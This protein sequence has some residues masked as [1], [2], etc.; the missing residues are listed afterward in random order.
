VVQE[1]VSVGRRETSPVK[2]SFGYGA[3]TE[4]SDASAALTTE[5]KQLDDVNGME[6]AM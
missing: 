5:T 6:F 1:A 4:T 3:S 2:I